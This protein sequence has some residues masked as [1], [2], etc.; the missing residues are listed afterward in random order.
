MDRSDDD[1]NRVSEFYSRTA[2]SYFQAQYQTSYRT[3]INVRHTKVLE[4]LDSLA[5]PTRARVL[6]AGCGPGILSRDLLARGFEVTSTDIT[7]QMLALTRR[8]TVGGA[9]LVQSSI[10]E[11]PFKDSS[12]DLVC[13][14]GV[15][16]YLH[17]YEQAVREFHRI[18]KPGGTLVL[19]TTSSWGPA[20]YLA[21][22]VERLKKSKRIQARFDV[23]PRHF[24][25]RRHNPLALR[26]YLES[27]FERTD[28]QYFFLLPYP[29]PLNRL[30]PVASEAIERWLDRLR[31][32]P[33]RYVGEGYLTISRKHSE[34]PSMK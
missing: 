22:I 32:S 6:D 11:L 26:R 18:L 23:D 25:V 14:C 2:E 16:E 15:I 33:L 8:V 1:R 13:S 10:E 12:F 27:L 20:N 31:H 29:R 34:V 7:A 3:F 30:F 19:P 4:V 5:L 24:T 9:R 17:S 21:P 28:E